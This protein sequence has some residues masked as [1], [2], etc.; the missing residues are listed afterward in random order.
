MQRYRF[1]GGKDFGLE[2][3]A[4]PL[5]QPRLDVGVFEQLA[6]VSGRGF[7][8]PFPTRAVNRQR[9]AGASHGYVEKTPLFLIVKRLVILSAQRTRVSQL[10]RKLDHRLAIRGRKGIADD[11]QHKYMFK[12]QALCTMHRHQLYCV[13]LFADGK[14][15][16]AARLSE[17]IEVFE[18]LPRLLGCGQRR[19]LPLARKFEN[20]LDRRFSWQF[21]QA[22]YGQQGSVSLS[23]GNFLPRMLY[24]SE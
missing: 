8:F 11:P 9:V 22:N 12:F 7:F 5:L 23:A 1:C 4:G 19:L 20:S 14:S 10:R 15:D 2:F 16:S 18:K 13:I 3:A 17:Q 6:Q 24:R 21:E